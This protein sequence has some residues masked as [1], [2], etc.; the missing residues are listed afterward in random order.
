MSKCDEATKVCDGVLPAKVNGSR[1]EKR[2]FNVHEISMYL[3]LS[4]PTIYRYAEEMK[5]PCFKI[6]KVLRF[7]V[8]EIEKW[9]K[10]FKREPIS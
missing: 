2:Y 7:D 10:A 6:G 4:S 8:L 3:G 5:I 9:M 1:M